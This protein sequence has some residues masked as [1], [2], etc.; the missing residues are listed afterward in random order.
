VQRAGGRIGQR[1]SQPRRDDLGQLVHAQRAQR[2]L[3][4]PARRQQRAEHAWDRRAGA[5]AEYNYRALVIQAAQCEPER[6]RGGQVQ[7]RD[8]VHYHQAAAAAGE[9]L[10]RRMRAEPDGEVSAPARRWVGP[11]QGS[12]QRAG[13]RLGKLG[14]QPPQVRAQKIGEPGE[15]QTALRLGG[16]GTQHLPALRPGAFGQPRQQS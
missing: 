4:R 16:D 8:V 13:Q 15:G 9:R 1:H 5:A 12:V 14:S 6:L 3:H 11:Q 10:Q 2:H 7:P